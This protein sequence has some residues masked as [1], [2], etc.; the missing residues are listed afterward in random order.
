MNV[1]ETRR[2]SE[3]PVALETQLLSKVQLRSV[4]WPSWSSFE[5]AGRLLV[6]AGTEEAGRPRANRAEDWS[7]QP[8][9]EGCWGLEPVV[10]A[11]VAAAAAAAAA[12]VVID[13][14]TNE[15]AG[16]LVRES[17]FSLPDDDLAE[18]GLVVV[19]CRDRA[20]LLREHL[21]RI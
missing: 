5:C 1:E 18:V 20:V 9:E 15:F 3:F 11:V 2:C 8:P 21:P 4:P 16:S 7:R 12:A 6:E 17:L 19:R 14:L 10:E 13:V